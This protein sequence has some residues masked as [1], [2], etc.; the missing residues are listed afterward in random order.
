[1]WRGAV[2]EGSALVFGFGVDTVEFGEGVFDDLFVRHV[3]SVRGHGSALSGVKVGARAVDGDVSVCVVGGMHEYGQSGE[4][5]VAQGRVERYGEF[6]GIE[7]GGDGDAVVDDEGNHEGLSAV[8]GAGDRL[9]EQVNGENAF[10]V[11]GTM[12]GQEPKSTEDEG[13]VGSGDRAAVAEAFLQGWNGFVALVE[14]A[15]S[16]QNRGAR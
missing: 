8:M 2:G 11:T 10:A 7:V 3:G 16:M 1:M 15:L 6:P 13:A 14:S 4:G 5:S 12:F 9:A